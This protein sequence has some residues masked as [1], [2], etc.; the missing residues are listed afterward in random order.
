MLRRG[1]LAGA[2]CAVG[3]APAA[4]AV[5]RLTLDAYKPSDG[6]RA[7]V[8][9]APL[10]DGRWYLADVRGTYSLFAAAGW[11]DPAFRRCGTPEDAPRRRSRGT[12]NGPV[13][14]D[15]ATAFAFLRSP[16]S[17]LACPTVPAGHGQFLVDTAGDGLSAAD[18]VTPVATIDRHRYEYAVR[19]TGR[20][21]TF[22]IDDRPTGDNY[23][24]LV[25]RVRAA[26]RRD[27][28]RGGYLRFGYADQAQCL[29][30][31]PAQGAAAARRRP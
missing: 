9:T 13:S 8:A 24:V 6:T 11:D 31:T 1:M 7:S 29:A 18:H 27:C 19:G 20:P 22:A 2:C 26:T 28:R 15:A 10:D 21:A 23:G 12:D 16:T 30:A 25:I 3:A 17:G 14:H 5:E 4:S